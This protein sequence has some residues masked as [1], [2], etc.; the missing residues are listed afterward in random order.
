[1]F[2]CNIHIQQHP[3]NAN[4]TFRYVNSQNVYMQLFAIFVAAFVKLIQIL[5]LDATF[6]QCLCFSYQIGKLGEGRRV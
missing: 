6:S 1:M 4:I 3:Q 2:I 5:L